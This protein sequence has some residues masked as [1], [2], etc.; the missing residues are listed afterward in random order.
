MINLY[1]NSFKTDNPDRQKEFD[2]CLKKNEDN[3]FIDHIYFLES[4]QNDLFNRP[5]F[6]DFFKAMSPA[7]VNIISN[8]DIYFD[9]TIQLANQIKQR[10]AWALTRWE[11]VEEY[12]KRQSKMVE[13]I[14]YFNRRNP[15]ATPKFSQD[16]WIMRGKP[17][18]ED[19]NFG[20]GINGCDN[21]IAWILKVNGYNVRNPSYS[22][23]CIH[24]HKTPTSR[25]SYTVP[26]P[27]L[28]VEPCNL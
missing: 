4:E 10:E 19:A 28:W 5:T 26:R 24:V 20:L 15:A 8:S 17:N 1:I 2:Y 13:V 16:T 12:D 6:S 22:I 3:P 23:R 25:N 27:Y 21:R 7:G 18:I 9:E 14:M 11:R